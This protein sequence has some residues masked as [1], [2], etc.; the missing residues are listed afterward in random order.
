MVTD[1]VSCG[2]GEMACYVSGSGLFISTLAGT[3]LDE[4]AE[5]WLDGVWPRRRGRGR[6]EPR[7]YCMVL[8]CALHLLHFALKRCSFEK[9]RGTACCMPRRWSW[10]VASCGLQGRDEGSVKRRSPLPRLASPKPSP[11]LSSLWMKSSP[12]RRG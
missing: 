8:Q 5:C 10:L 3:R 11:L 6:A 1:A 9:E 2:E 12:H 7:T 4:G